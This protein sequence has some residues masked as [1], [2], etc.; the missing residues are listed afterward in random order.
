MPSHSNNVLLN[1]VWMLGRSVMQWFVLLPHSEHQESIRKIS[2]Q[3]SR[4][5]YMR[6]S[7]A[8]CEL[9]G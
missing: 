2:I 9:R 5:T 4:I 3:P 6:Q 7:V 8:L 1:A